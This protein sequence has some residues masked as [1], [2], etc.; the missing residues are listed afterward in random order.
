MF[1]MEVL[2]APMKGVKSQL[3]LAK[4]ATK[5]RG[6]RPAK[7]FQ[8]QMCRRLHSKNVAVSNGTVDGSVIRGSLA[9][10]ST[11]EVLPGQ[12]VAGQENVSESAEV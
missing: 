3:R 4:S 6:G 12:G 2:K 8:F 1:H 10:G 7:V 11:D 9:V 5:R